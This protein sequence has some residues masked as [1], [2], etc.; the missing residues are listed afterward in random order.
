MPARDRLSTTVASNGLMYPFR[1]LLE[2]VEAKSLVTKMS[3]CAIGMPVNGVA[4]P[5]AK[6]ASAAA[7]WASVISGRTSRKAFSPRCASIR[8]R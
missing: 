7:A 4:S 6:R 1:I 8:A 5:R 2:A 3:L